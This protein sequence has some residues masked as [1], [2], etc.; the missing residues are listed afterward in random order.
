[1]CNPKE[2]QGL[3]KAQLAQAISIYDEG[4]FE[5]LQ[6]WSLSSIFLSGRDSNLPNHLLPSQLP[7]F[8]IMVML[9]RK[10]CKLMTMNPEITKVEK[11]WVNCYLSHNSL[12][13]CRFYWKTLLVALGFRVLMLNQKRFGC[14]RQ[15]T[16]SLCFVFLNLITKL[17]SVSTPF[18]ISLQPQCHSSPIHQLWWSW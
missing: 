18:S 17:G 4:S 12:L 9:A 8:T 3:S 13:C 10:S 14:I 5:H 1:M 6:V 16:I 15:N 11:I 2:S 7:E